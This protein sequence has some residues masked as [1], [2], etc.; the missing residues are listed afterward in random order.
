MEKM[1]IDY[2]DNTVILSEITEINNI[3]Y[4]QIT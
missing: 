4:W 3:N 2:S 1:K